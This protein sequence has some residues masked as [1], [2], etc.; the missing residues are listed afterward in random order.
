MFRE[1]AAKKGYAAM[2]ANQTHLIMK[3]SLIQYKLVEWLHWLD[4]TESLR[5]D[6]FALFLTYDLCLYHFSCMCFM[7]IVWCQGY[8]A[9]NLAVWYV[10]WELSELIAWAWYQVVWVWCELVVIVVKL[11]AMG[12]FFLFHCAQL[13]QVIDSVEL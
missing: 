5:M 8:V 10:M 11:S 1:H 7:R 3:C 13:Y 6:E 2:A 9:S 4:E 12:F